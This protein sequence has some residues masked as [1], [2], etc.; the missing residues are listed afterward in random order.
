MRSRKPSGPCASSSVSSLMPDF[1]DLADSTQS[2][3]ATSPVH[4]NALDNETIQ[5][6]QMFFERG[7]NTRITTG[8]KLW[9]DK[10]KKQTRLSLDSMLNLNEKFCAE[11]SD[12][13][14]GY[15]TFTRLRPFWVRLP[16]VKDRDTCLCKKY[17]NIQLLADKL[18]QLGVLKVKRA[19]DVLSQISCSTDNYRCMFREC[20]ICHDQSVEFLVNGVP[21]DDTIVVW[22]EW[23]TVDQE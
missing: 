15:V 21:K 3:A 20:S 14:I 11:Y 7:D 18:L 4:G 16:T 6:V 1:Q 13:N 9:Q 8:K 10:I 23:T 12:R 19:E 17:E 22:S 5:L 2:S